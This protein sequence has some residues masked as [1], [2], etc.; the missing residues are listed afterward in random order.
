MGHNRWNLLPQAPMEILCTIPGVSPLLAQLFYNRGLVEPSQREL[1]LAGDRRLLN[2]PLLLPDIHRAMSRIYRALLSGENIAVY[3]D[4]DADGVAGTALLVQG[5]TALGAR[6]IPYIPHRVTEGHGLKTAALEG[7]QK[8]GI[9]LVVTVDCGVTGVAE[10]K[11][12][13]RMGLDV[14]ITD[15]HVPLDELPPALAV[16]DPRRPDSSYPFSELAGVGV[17]FK[18]LQALF[19]SIGRADESDRLMDLVA[20]GTVADMMPLKGENRY[21]VRGGLKLINQFP[22]LG[23][24]E[25]ITRAGLEIGNISS[26]SI[27]W[28]LAP[29]LNAAGRLDHASISYEL[30]VTDSP[31]EACELAASL[32]KRNAER[33]RLTAKIFA[34]VKE[35]LP[36]DRIE[37][38][39]MTG[40]KDY[41]EGIIGVIAGKLVSEFYRPAIVIKIGERTSNGSC[42]SIPEFDIVY[43]LSQ[44]SHLFT[45]FGGHPR[46]AGFSLPTSKLPYLKELLAQMAAVKLAGVDLRPRINIDAEVNLPELGGDT[47]LAIQKLAPFGEG[48][49]FPT[50]LSRGVQVL[51]CHSIGNNEEHLK[52]KLRQGGTIWDAV[53]FGFGDCLKEVC[54]PMDIVYNLEVDRWRGTEKLRLNILDFAPVDSWS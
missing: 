38:L 19:Q 41:P 8:Q 27:T 29:R 21:L 48:N 32:E 14:V 4:F 53:C 42:R 45:Q 36:A 35:Q 13:K 18:L 12:A 28:A 52:M 47:Y 16:V 54:S 11:R 49:P 46:A 20:L 37:P 30:L 43:A 51:E 2:D 44:C 15:H 17:A 6:V 7:L 23:V 5:L 1:F 9:S 50:F 33:Q 24:R 40:D 26:E 22:R 31:E 3:G 34:R 39:L 25:M 10:V